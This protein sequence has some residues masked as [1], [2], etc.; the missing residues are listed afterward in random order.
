MKSLVCENSAKSSV[1][2]KLVR[3][4]SAALQHLTPRSNMKWVNIYMEFFFGRVSFYI[5]VGPRVYET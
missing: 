2:T 5:K 4:E 3:N 1:G